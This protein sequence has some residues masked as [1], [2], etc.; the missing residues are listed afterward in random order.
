MSRSETCPM[1]IKL[2]SLSPRSYAPDAPAASPTPELGG[3][4]TR[5]K[6]MRGGSAAVHPQIPGI[7]PFPLRGKGVRG[8]GRCREAASRIS[9]EA[10]S[11][12][13]LIRMGRSET[14]PYQQTIACQWTLRRLCAGMVGGVT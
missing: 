7:S 14:C 8:I 12:I 2:S 1:L 6:G 13:S 4:E 11:R 3:G 10:A 5:F 9:R